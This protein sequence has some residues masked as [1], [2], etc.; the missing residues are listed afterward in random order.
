MYNNFR[1]VSDGQGGETVIEPKKQIAR[2][3][4]PSLA[5][6]RRVSELRSKD[7]VLGYIKSADSEGICRYVS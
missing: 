1:R 6:I 3:F 7:A 4:R 5:F 2:V